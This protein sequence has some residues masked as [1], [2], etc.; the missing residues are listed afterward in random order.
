MPPSDVQPRNNRDARPQLA[1]LRRSGG[2]RKQL[3]RADQHLEAGAEVQ[4][5]R[6]VR[7]HLRAT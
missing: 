1:R 4:L 5:D 6:A 7:L 3:Q 2:K